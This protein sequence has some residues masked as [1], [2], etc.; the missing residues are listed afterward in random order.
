M[1]A[2]LIW[3]GFNLAD[4]IKDANALIKDLQVE[5]LPPPPAWR[6]GLPLVGERLAALGLTI[7]QQGAAFFAALRPYLGQVGNWLLARS[8]QLGGGMLELALSPVS[9]THLDVYKRQGLIWP[10]K[11]P[12]M[13]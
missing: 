13:R 7:D 1:A 11:W 10:R 3:L 6:A 8:A 12:T 2:P 9:Y 4:H 5:G